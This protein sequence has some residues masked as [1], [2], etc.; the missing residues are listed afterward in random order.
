MIPSQ[1]IMLHFF[2][3][4][5]PARV[6]RAAFRLGG[7]RS[8]LLSYGNIFKK[9]PW[10]GFYFVTYLFY[11]IITLLSTLASESLFYF[12]YMHFLL[13]TLLFFTPAFFYFFLAGEE[14][15]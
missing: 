2:V 13:R 12:S 11:R 7:E 3:L 6:E 15:L 5:F 1:D 14:L 4:A 10:L 9:F 8:I